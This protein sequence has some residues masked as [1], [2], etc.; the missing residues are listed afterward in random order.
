M[1]SASKTIA[2]QA[3][4][5]RRTATS[6]RTIAAP[7][8]LDPADRGVLLAAARI[9][10]E[11]ASET[12]KR[13]KATARDEARYERAYNAALPVATAHIATLPRTT[14]LDKVALIFA[15]LSQAGYLICRLAAGAKGGE[16]HKILTADK[17]L[18]AEFDDAARDLA[19][20]LAYKVAKNGSTPAAEGEK[21]S[22][23]L[24]ALRSEHRVIRLAE[25]VDTA[26]ADVATAAQ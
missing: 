6:L 25:R 24:A 1:T 15:S 26:M 19:T 17:I 11:M 3:A 4:A 14:T 23:Y 16:L 20:T 18:T 5:A 2:N 22:A 21:L 9:V 8:D 13:A 7:T 10:E 12:A